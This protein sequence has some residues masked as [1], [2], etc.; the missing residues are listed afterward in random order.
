VNWFS[1]YRVHHRVADRFQK[2]RAFLLGDAAHIHSPVGGQGMNTGIGDA[3]NLAWKLAAALRGGTSALAETY[4]AERVA[5]ARRLVATTDRA[6]TIITSRGPRARWV[7][8]SVAPRVIPILAS[9]KAVRRLMFR[10][11]SQT[12]IHYRSSPLSVGAA[13]R[14]RGGDRLPWVPLDGAD[15]NF[16]PLASL[17]WQ[18]HVYGD[19]PAEIVEVC[20]QRRLALHV[21]PWQ[22]TMRRP[23]LRRH[24]GYLI[25]PDG[26][27]GLAEPRADA[28]KLQAYLDE[29]GLR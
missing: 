5:F 8:L 28:A 27:V 13:G 12:T 21:F 14:V 3:V 20:R 16:T 26:H 7:R 17:D 22:D 10:T 25:R 29:R 2:G 9:R 24:A 19:A 6:F 11:I 4:E 18:L 1:T 15:D 23:G